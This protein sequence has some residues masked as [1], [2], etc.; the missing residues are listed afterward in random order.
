MKVSGQFHD[1]AALSPE[2]SR[3]YPLNRRLRGPQ[4]QCG[5]CGVEKYFLLEPWTSNS[6]HTD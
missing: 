3:Q 4:S 5:R 6:L 2:K 1:P